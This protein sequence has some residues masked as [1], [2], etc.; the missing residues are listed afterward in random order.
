MSSLGKTWSVKT[1]AITKEDIQAVENLVRQ[2]LTYEEAGAILGKNA[3]YVQNVVDRY[4]VGK[5][6]LQSG[7]ANTSTQA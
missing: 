3:K 7:S 2:K 4:T 6:R 5:R 1:R